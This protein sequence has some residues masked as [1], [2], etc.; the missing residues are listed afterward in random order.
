MAEIKMHIDKIIINATLHENLQTS[1][2]IVNYDIRD[3]EVAKMNG[4]KHPK[5]KKDK[6]MDKMV[7]N[8]PKML[9]RMNKMGEIPQTIANMDKLNKKYDNIFNDLFST[10]RIFP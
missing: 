10:C 6:I 1:F 3:I 7:K 2:E 8:K 4:E 9:K 5:F